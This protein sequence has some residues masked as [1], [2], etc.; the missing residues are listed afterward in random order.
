MP[1]LL[2][3][4]GTSEAAAL[5]RQAVGVPGLAVTT[6]LAGATRQPASLPGSVRIGG[7][8][9]VD[10]MANALANDR[11]D[12]VADATHPFAATISAHAAAACARLSLPRLAI[13]RPPWTPQPADRWITVADVE[14]AADAVN[15]LALPQGHSVLLTIGRRDLAPFTRC[16][17]TGFVVRS[18]DPPD[19]PPAL[20][21]YVAV[22]ARGPFT[23][24]DELRLFDGHGIAAVVTRN[25]GGGGASAKLAA[26]RR[27]AIPV[28]MIER[29][30]A[31][32][33]PRV[34]DEATALEWICRT[35][36][37]AG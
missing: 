19:A 32:P 30:A 33:P 11:I 35:L 22:A 23:E 34:D 1:R 28:I 17:G 2:I 36:S 37:I 31:P 15:R 14:D 12:L 24:A 5:A 27:R 9:G 13:W 21:R 26:A 10:G 3:L 16:A 6:S 4:G 20:S 8:G 25:S 7:F 29:P 18:V